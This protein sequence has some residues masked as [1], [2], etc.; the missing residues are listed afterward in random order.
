[1]RVIRHIIAITVVSF[2]SMPAD[3]APTYFPDVSG[4]W[5]PLSSDT[6]VM[7]MK[8]ANGKITIG[9]QDLSCT[10][11]DL[12]PP[13]FADPLSPPSVT[14][15][16]VCDEESSTAYTKETLTVLQVGHDVFLI[17]ASVLLRLVNENTEPKEDKVYTNRAP[18]ISIYRRMR[19]R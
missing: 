11:T 2:G 14:A 10:L 16:G 18:T 7:T 1:M 17:D 6:R 9:S 8:S 13:E 3:S 12:T 19:G 15:M 4:I 5:K